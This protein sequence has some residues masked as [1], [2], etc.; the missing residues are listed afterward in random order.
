[1][2]KLVSR[3]ESAPRENVQ[4]AIDYGKAW[5]I[6]IVDYV[7][8]GSHRPITDLEDTESARCKG[9]EMRGLLL[10]EL[11]S[12]ITE[13]AE[14]INHGV[15]AIECGK[16]GCQ[17]AWKMYGPLARL[18]RQEIARATAKAEK[19][20]DWDSTREQALERLAFLRHWSGENEN[21]IRRIIRMS[22]CEV[23]DEAEHLRREPLMPK[24]KFII[25]A[26]VYGG[27]GLAAASLFLDAASAAAELP[28][29]AWLAPLADAGV[30]LAAGGLA[31]KL[32][33]VAISFFT[34][35]KTSMNKFHQE[36]NERRLRMQERD[37]ASAASKAS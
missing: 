6:T 11:R 34:G 1:M 23:A 12:K 3:G 10:D 13:G 31:T 9:I 26:A 32:P 5:V 30:V 35:I 22:K 16:T 19:L 29:A 2:F 15:V 27:I 33:R 17:A 25:K 4:N 7:Q 24:E 8:R 14:E 18:Q 20:S 21:N 37:A 36:V 28:V